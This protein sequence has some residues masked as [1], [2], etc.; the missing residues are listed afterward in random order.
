VEIGEKDH[1]KFLRK[2]GV[3][4][5]PW[6]HGNMIFDEMFHVPTDKE[7]ATAMEFANSELSWWTYSDLLDCDNYGFLWMGKIWEYYT[8][9][10]SGRLPWTIGGQFGHLNNQGHFWNYAQTESGPKHI[11]YNK[12]IVP[13]SFKSQG[14]I[15]A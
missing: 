14:S 5:Y 13:E 12:I 15:T 11:N 10:W 6:D 9:H 1:N 8:R 2:F 3:G 4:G 7:V